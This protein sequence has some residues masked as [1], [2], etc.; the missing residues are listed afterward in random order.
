MNDVQQSVRD[1]YDKVGW[2]LTDAEVYQN[3]R[4]E[5]L[6]PVSRDY[7]H[8]CH[9]RVARHLPKSGTYLLDAGSGPIQYAEYLAYSAGYQYRVCLD[10]SITALKEARKR[11]A[12]HG[13]YVVADVTQMP[14]KN[15]VMDGAVTLHTFHHLP[16]DTQ[17]QAYLEIMRVLTE[18]GT[19]VV[20]NGWTES[21]LM[22]GLRWLVSF[23]EKMGSW[24][25]KIRKNS[26]K[27]PAQARNFSNEA[28]QK[29]KGTYIT[30]IDYQWL[31]NELDGVIPYEVF[32]WRSVSVRF[33]RAVFH[34]WLFGKV[35]LAVLY[36]LEEL[37]PEYFGRVGQYP[38]IVLKKV[39]RA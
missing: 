10:L 15:E 35:K 2:Q 38:L 29:P 20:V 23:M 17:K 7:I 34:P 27:V 25:L 18:P 9:L 16:A 1:F 6:R 26:G 8:R 5:D 3:A 24:W 31:K 32:V 21:A 14:F 37:F 22:N 11:I 28:V 19:A 4:Y 12:S 13:L 30:K 39:H 36:R 33:L